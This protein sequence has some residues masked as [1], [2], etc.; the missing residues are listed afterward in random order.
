MRLETI[1]DIHSHDES[2]VKKTEVHERL[3]MITKGS[4]VAIGIEFCG[5]MDKWTQPM[6]CE[7]SSH[8]LYGPFWHLES[9]GIFGFALYLNPAIN[10]K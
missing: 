8:S 1:L 7:H 5:Y 9:I 2:F 6:P 3:Q 4:F 10:P